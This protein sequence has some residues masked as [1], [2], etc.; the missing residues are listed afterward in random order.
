MKFTL[1][2]GASS[3][4][5]L[6]L[7][8]ECAR[9]GRNV[10]MVSLPGEDLCEKADVIAEDSGVI[11]D[12]I[13]IDLT[14]HKAPE[15]IHS[16]V[17]KNNY[18]VDFLIN[19]AGFGGAGVFAEHSANYVK[20]MIDLNVRATTLMQQ[21]FI[22]DLIRNKPSFLMNTASIMAGVSAPYKAMYSATKTYVKNLTIALS[23]EL[24]TEGVS[25]SVLLPGATPTN[26]VVTD[27]IK[28]GNF[29]ARVSVMSPSEVARIGIAKAL[30]GKRVITTGFKNSL[31][32]GLI[33]IIPR[34]IVAQIAVNQYHKTNK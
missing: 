16:W 31:V 2:T 11:T 1:I 17:V 30:I 10:L 27:Q 33:N 14:D 29:A 15:Q 32:L 24:E 13:E 6:E 26:P 19:N 5:G 7:S 20:S 21:Q 3:G 23:Y 25:V 4:I 12:A 18:Q 28:K 22:P 34:A 9:L 8:R